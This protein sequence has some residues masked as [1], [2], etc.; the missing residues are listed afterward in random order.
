M[1]VPAAVAAVLVASYL[2]GSIPFAFLLTRWVRGVDVRTVGSGNVGATNAS[3]V[4][5]PRW[6]LVVFTLDALKGALPVLLLAGAAGVAD[7]ALPHLRMGCGLAAILGHVF[8]V[9]LGFRGGKG[10]A[11]G[12]GVLTALA[13]LPALSALGVFFVALLAFRYVS[14]GS[15]I[16]SAALPVLAWLYGTDVEIV[17]FCGAVAA[18]VIVLH[19]K[20]IARI[21]AG[22]EPR[23]FQKKRKEDGGPHA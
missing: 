14:L 5:G 13:T 10:V 8:P 20:N 15:V 21:A 16:A 9:F 4:L 12:A 23:V 7:D 11:T 19:R 1:P 3:R 2:A 18:L 22:T 17:V 6:F